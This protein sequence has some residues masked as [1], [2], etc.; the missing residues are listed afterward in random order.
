MSLRPFEAKQPQIHG[1]APAIAEDG[2]ITYS[3]PPANSGP[4]HTDNT[5][6]VTPSF[7]A[8]GHII[9]KQA[10]DLGGE[11]FGPGGQI[12]VM[13]RP[14][15]PPL[16]GRHAHILIISPGGGVKLVHTPFWQL[17]QVTW[18]ADA[19]ALAVG[20]VSRRTELIYH[21]DARE[22]L[23]RGWQS[24]SWSPAG[25]ELL[26]RKGVLL[27]IWSVSAPHRITVLGRTNRQFAVLNVAWLANRAPL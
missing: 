10:G 21:G 20:S 23:P 3:V 26:L 12:A 16:H 17:A 2:E 15:D 1:Q 7:S 19:I 24:L 8:P 27:G 11:S 5:V 22:M 6:W 25:T 18:Q 13:D 9:Y 14:Y 4:A